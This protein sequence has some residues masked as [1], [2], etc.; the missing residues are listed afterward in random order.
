MVTTQVLVWHDLLFSKTI[1]NDNR[2]YMLDGFYQSI[3][4]FFM[5]Y[6]LYSPSTFVHSNGKDVSDRTRMGVLVGSSAVIA[7]NTYILMNCYRWDW[8]TVLINVVSSLLIFLWTGIYSS[9]EASTTFYNAGAQ[10]YSAL[11][12]W[13]VLLLTVT[14]CLLPRFTV[15]AFQKVFFPLDVDIIREQVSQGKFK[16]LDQ[17]EGTVPPRAAAAAAAAGS[18]AFSDESSTSSDFV[19]PIQP[20][21]KQDPFSDEQQIYSPSIVPTIHTHRPR[22]SNGTNYASSLDTTRL[23]HPQPVDYIHQSSER[24]RHSFERVQHGFG[25]THD[26]SAGELTRESSFAGAQEPHSPL[27]G[28]H[29]PPFHA[30]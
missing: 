4:C 16:F 26:Y 7:S 29:D 12:Y 30:I 19:K 17:Y 8:L 21:L 6:L 14:I 5:P 1:T 25:V 23:P 9:L 22:G 20:S 28:A 15:K 27:H 13:V 24:T 18:T 3:I 11:S 10:V 2:L